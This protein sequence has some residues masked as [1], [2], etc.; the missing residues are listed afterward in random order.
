MRNIVIACGG[1]G[2]HL[3]PGIALA[4][5]LEEKGCPSWLFISQKGVDSRLSSKYP[6]LAFV[7]LPGAPLIKSPVGL[8]RFGHG[9]AFSFLR[10]HRFYKKVGADAL[11]GFGGFSSF[12]PA[13]A[14]RARRMPVFIHEANRA[15]G[16]A[17]RFLAKRSTRLYLPEGMQL[18]GISSEIIRNIGYP[19]R[20]EFRRIPRERAR[21]QLGIALEDRLLVVL[22][23]SQGATSLNS[24]VKGNIERLAKEGISIYCL[25]G[26]NNESSG[27]IQM[28][29]PKE[30][31]SVTSRFVPF[32][33]EMNV[34]LSAADLVLSRAGAGAISEIVRC[35]VPSILVP[36]PYAADNH[37]YLNA[38]YLERK[39]GGIIC[40]QDKMD[41]V[42]FDEVREVMFNEEF[43]A[44][45]RR[46]LFAMDGGDVSAR[47]AD[48]LM[49]CL[50]ENPVDDS[51]QGGVLRMVG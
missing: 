21:K 26:M 37:Q 46:N 13:M 25:T 17:V 40:L 7:P 8:A 30:Q 10:A 15:V 29:G 38:S 2:G 14:A 35:R 23:G 18:E 50:K 48:D 5:S 43:R 32:T 1:T 9:F 20:K 6:N 44:I 27:V 24:W 49:Q 22:G 51:L 28:D 19:L 11:V 12:G 31:Q 39:G 36:Y 34:V 45:L 42:L 16:K 47:L 4:Q 33:D 3:T 41:E